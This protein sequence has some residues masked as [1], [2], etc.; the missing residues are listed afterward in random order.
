[1]AI[2]NRSKDASEQRRVMSVVAQAVATGATGMIG[3]V[4]HAAT[5][6][7][8]QMAAF[9]ISGSPTC[10]VHVHRFIVGTGFTSWAVSGV[11]AQFAYGTSGVNARGMSL[12]ASGS[13]LLNLL[14]ND[15]LVYL[16][17][18]TNAGCAFF[19]LQAV[20]KPL[21]DIKTYFGISG[22]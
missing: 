1:M 13:T 20:I 18:G 3:I 15:V 5:L 21:Q 19:S 7:G 2:V 6:D 8:L 16:T 12:L 22:I 14:P 17:A 4:P 11:E 9:G 10:A